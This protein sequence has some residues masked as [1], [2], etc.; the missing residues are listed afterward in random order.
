MPFFEKLKYRLLRQNIPSY[1]KPELYEKQLFNFDSDV[2][3]ATANAYLTG[4]WQSYKFFESI[5]S[6][7]LNDFEFSE[8]PAKIQYEFI[9]KIHQQNSV[10]VHIRRGDYVSNPEYTKIHGVCSTDYYHRAIEYI[11]SK[12]ENPAFYFFSDDMDWVKKN[13]TVNNDCVYVTGTPAGKDFYEM[14]LMSICKHNI[15]ANSS[16][17]WWGA[18]LN[19]NTEKIVIAPKL[20]MA[21]PTIDTTDLIPANWIRI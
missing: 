17:S 2:L 12:V 8:T 18:W 16:F 4:Y 9:D 11:C 13:I 10:S 19:K 5:R 15:I 21:D 1:R 3:K 14:Y 7:L 20:W 6:A